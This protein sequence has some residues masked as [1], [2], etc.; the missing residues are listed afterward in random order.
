MHAR[1][2]WYIRLDTHTLTQ[3]AMKFKNRAFT[4]ALL[5]RILKKLRVKGTKSTHYEYFFK[6]ALNL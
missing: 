2:Q 6:S 4:G 3:G 1:T 5:Q